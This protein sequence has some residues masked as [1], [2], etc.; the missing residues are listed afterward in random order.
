VPPPSPLGKEGG[1]GRGTRVIF[2]ADIEAQS[3]DI[4]DQSTYIEDQF[5]DL[6]GQF[7]DVYRI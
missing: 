2:P 3:T 7:E 5:T 4:E 6:K 1:R